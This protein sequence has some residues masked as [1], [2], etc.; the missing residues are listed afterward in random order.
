[1]NIF[2]A[3]IEK[4]ILPRV[5]LRPVRTNTVE[6]LELHNSIEKIGFL[7]SISVR[8]HPD[9]PGMYEILDGVYRYNV[10]KD[11]E[12]PSIP[13]ILKEGELTDFDLMTIQ[14]QANA[15]RP[16]TKPCEFARQ[17]KRI[18]KEI[19]DITISQLSVLVSKS[20]HWV[21]IQLNLLFLEPKYQLAVDRGEI[22]LQN[23]YMLC[24][25]HARLRSKYALYA[26]T[27]PAS[28]FSALAASVI[29][30]FREAIRQGKLDAFFT[31]EFTPQPYLRPLREVQWEL[32]K[33]DEGPLIL[34]QEGCKTALDG[35][36][37]ALQ[38]AIN[39]DKDSVEKQRRRFLSKTRK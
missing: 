17:L 21:K 30:Q 16:T 18:Q 7:N 26:K 32:T 15:V 35:W 19:P 25:I 11:L 29:K 23:A 34:A 3:P 10:A 31:E 20:P 22:C 12:L 37:M 9:Q 33:C 4:L 8:H 24:R 36:K 27:M 6:Y 13:V 5:L 14:I 1:M 38:W 28:E 39:L 2:N